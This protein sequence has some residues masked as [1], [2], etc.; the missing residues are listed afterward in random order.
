MEEM[1]VKYFLGKINNSEKQELF[2]CIDKDQYLKDE[3]IR[4]Q[5]LHAIN[6]SITYP[7][8]VDEGIKSL[9]VFKHTLITKE[10]GKRVRLISQVAAIFLILIISTFFI[11]RN[12][13]IN[14][15]N[16]EL[17]VLQVPSGQ[18]AQLTLSDGTIV[19][20]NA[21]STLKYPSQFYGKSR[22]VFLEGEAYFDVSENRKKP[23]IV[24]TDKLSL[25][26]LGTEFNITSY[27]KSE[28][29]FT[30]LVDGSLKIIDKANPAKTLT[31]TPN[32]LI[33]YKDNQ[34]TSLSVSNPD[35]VL[36]REGIYSFH[37]DKFID[38]I[39]RLELYYDIEIRLEHPEIHNVRFT[40]KFRQRD[41]IDEILQILSKIHSF[42]I[43]EDREN[44]LIIISK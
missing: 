42:K 28:N 27:S 4:L 19:W 26:V 20:L 43:E 41:G 16:T 39:K 8:S 32:Q 6:Q 13:I 17:N 36:W 23:F 35:Y 11:T 25:E 15:N 10:R 18:R 21:Q 22:T 1:L 5:N 30:Y 14:S 37:N 12:S 33:V 31:L 2:K 34:M 44:N 3:Y 40:G 24:N 29:T 9:N 38:I 7:S